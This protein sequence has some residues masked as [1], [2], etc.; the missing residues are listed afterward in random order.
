MGRDQLGEFE[1]QVL[2]A[3]LRH[4]GE[5]Y[6]VPVVQELEARTNREVAPAAVYIVLR[7]LEDKGLLTSRFEE[8]TGSGRTRRYFATTPL[9]VEKLRESRRTMLRLWEGLDVLAEEG[10]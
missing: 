9:A 10:R 1:H 8:E 2:L 4:G 7:R 5:S 3:V 6:S